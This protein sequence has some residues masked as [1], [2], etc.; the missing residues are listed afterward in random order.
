MGGEV[1]MSATGLDVFDTTLQKTH[2]WL[3][4]LMQIMEWDDKDHAYLALRATL[5]ALRDRLTVDE[6]A[7]LA[8][9]LPMLIRGF[10]YEGWDPAAKARRVRYK[11]EFLAEVARP[12]HAQV[13]IDPEPIVR[14]VFTLLS[15]RISEGEIA[16]IRHV[17]PRELRE[18]WTPE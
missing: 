18:L 15:R 16:D 4:E 1:A 13:P 11:S 12:F 14:G 3:N 8:A 17:L 2:R 5:H 10:F 9:Q 7:H 6:V